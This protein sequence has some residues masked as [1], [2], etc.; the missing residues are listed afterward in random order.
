MPLTFE[1]TAA[2]SIASAVLSSKTVNN[3]GAITVTTAV[4]D[5]QTFAGV[6]NTG[7]G[8]I[9]FMGG[10]TPASMPLTFENTAALSIAAA[11]LSAKTVSSSH[12]I[13][14][15]TAVAD[16]ET[17]GNVTFTSFGSI[18]FMGGL[19]P[20]SMPLTF[21]NTADLS[22]A[23]A[24]L[25][26]K[27]VYNSAAITVTTA[28][29]SGQTFSG[30]ILV[31][32]GSITFMGGNLPAS[33][34]VTFTNTATLTI[35][36][37]VITGKNVSGSG[38]LVI[39]NLSSNLF[40]V[41]N[42]LST[43]AMTYITSNATQTLNNSSTLYQ[44]NASSRRLLIQSSQTL[45]CSAN[46][47][48]TVGQEITVAQW[49]GSG[50]NAV[51]RSSTPTANIIVNL[52]DNT[53]ANFSNIT[54]NS[55]TYVVEEKMTGTHIFLNDSLKILLNLN[56]WEYTV[57]SDE[58][59]RNQL[60]NDRGANSSLARL[61]V[62]DTDGNFGKYILFDVNDINADRTKPLS[63]VAARIAANISTAPT[64]RGFG[65]TS[66]ASYNEDNTRTAGGLV[67]ST[68][69]YTNISG[70]GEIQ[71]QG[72]GFGNQY[73]ILT[74]RDDGFESVDGDGRFFQ[75]FAYIYSYV[76]YER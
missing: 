33:M 72:T 12:A 66:T 61:N 22:I 31:G 3:S 59:M 4:V 13:T 69:E 64:A 34:P 54:L 55:V 39:S 70:I 7:S 18:S 43:G 38:D 57:G 6:T 41:N 48:G 67:R 52:G 35:G 73:Q 51:A 65:Y 27:T 37:D 11:V 30:V 17:F 58:A 56:N 40:S 44:S 28:V 63:L 36:A 19:T 15:T 24:V 29:V 9:S 32:S 46:Q 47:I 60:R 23:S 2:L 16:G 45:T 71:N 26:G 74:I 76:E 53:N 21:T 20:E 68:G 8:S 50:V 5:G 1:N 42:I 14:V 10:L 62:Y 49:A 75:L 25:S